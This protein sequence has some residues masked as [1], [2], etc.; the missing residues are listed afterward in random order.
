MT[1][2]WVWRVSLLA[3]ISLVAVAGCSDSGEAVDGD[4]LPSWNAGAAKTTIIE[5]VSA[6]TDE[7]GADYV[8]P[9]DR[10][11]VFDN[12]GTLWV[13]YPLYPQVSFTFDRIKTLAPRHPEWTTT[14]PFKA[15]LEDDMQTVVA[16]G[17]E[18]VF[19]MAIATHTGMTA[20]EFEETV[21]QWLATSEHP[22]LKRPYTE[23]VYQPQLELLAYLHT[24]GFTTFIV[25]GG[26]GQFIRPWSE[27]IYGI[28]PHRVVGSSFASEFQIIEGKPVLV[29]LPRIASLNEKA[30][31]PVS[32]YNHIGS[33]PIL[34]FGNSDGDMQMLQYTT[35]GDGRRLGLLLHHD[36]DDREFAYDRDSQVGQ[37][38]EALDE[39]ARQDWTVVSMKNDFATVFPPKSR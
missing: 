32:I 18:G 7:D 37:L 16:S 35:A 9:A 3:L 21:S 14:Q 12:D 27:E 11:A 6:V 4:P 33:R 39:A 28:P 10:I 38:D 17:E 31:K 23:C 8:R 19:E 29:R 5:F 25:S 2:R 20:E 1:Q 22:T 30:D 15:I 24:N 34:A 13:E 36:D 26:S